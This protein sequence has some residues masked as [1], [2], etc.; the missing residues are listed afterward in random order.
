MSDETTL[1][2]C[3]MCGAAWP[4]V[5]VRWIGFTHTHNGAFSAG[6]RGECCDCGLITRAFNDEAEAIAAWNARATHGMLTAEQVQEA[7]YKH[8]V[9]DGS[10]YYVFKGSFRT[11]ADDLNAMLSEL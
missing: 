7:V 6:Y 5:Q 11:I 4:S 2:P 10:V 1:L 3:P 9:D 8:G